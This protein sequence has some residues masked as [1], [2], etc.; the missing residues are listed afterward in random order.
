ML[1]ITRCG[2]PSEKK[3]LLTMMEYYNELLKPHNPNLPV[4]TFASAPFYISFPHFFRL[5]FFLNDSTGR[6]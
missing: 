6:D 2:E 5:E 4:S 1:G 3:R